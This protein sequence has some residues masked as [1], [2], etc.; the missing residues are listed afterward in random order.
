MLTVAREPSPAPPLDK[1]SARVAGYRALVE[2]DGELRMDLGP[3]AV[4][5]IR[6][7]SG[8]PSALDLRLSTS[9]GQPVP[10]SAPERREDDVIVRVTDEVEGASGRL[11]LSDGE[12]QQLGGWELAPAVE[13]PES[14]R[15]RLAAGEDL[16]A[17]G[18]SPRQRVLARVEL[19]RA[20]QREGDADATIAAWD[21]VA[22]EAREAG[23]PTEV[24]RG[25]RAAAYHCLRARRFDDALAHLDEAAGI[26]RR[27]RNV[28]GTLR[29]TDY[30]A[31]VLL[32]RS[33]YREAEAELGV[34]VARA[35]R[36]GLE[37]EHAWLSR[38][39]AVLLQHL[40]R[41]ADALTTLAGLRG[42]YAQASEHERETF[43]ERVSYDIDRG[44]VALIG[45]ERGAVPLNLEQPAT[46]FAEARA[47]AARVGR[48]DLEADA[49]TNLL[50]IAYLRNDDAG[51]ATLV[52]EL[53]ALD[54]EHSGYSARFVEIVEAELQLRA[55]ELATARAG[56]AAARER[57]LAESAGR[58]SEYSWRALYGIARAL[59]AQG[60]ERGGLA[61]LEEAAAALCAVV[62]QTRIEGA[63]ALFVRDRHELF[64][65]GVAWALEAGQPERAFTFAQRSQAQLAVALENRT[66]A[67]R[68]S[69]EERAQYEV[70]RGQ[71]LDAREAHV[72]AGR[73]HELLAESGRLAAER[74][75]DAER[76]AL[77]ARFERAHAYLDRV[78]PVSAAGVSL[79]EVR[80]ALEDDEALL[81]SADLGDGRVDFLVRGGSQVAR[82]V[83]VQQRAPLEPLLESLHDIALLYVVASSA[84]ARSLHRATD[85]AGRLWLERFSIAYLPHAGLLGRTPVDASQPP[86][87]VSDPE[88]DLPHA[89]SEA[90]AVRRQ[91]PSARLLRGRDATRA[92]VLEALDGASLFH[93][94]GH[95]VLDAAN[96]WD[97]R[98][99]LAGG[100]SLTVEDLLVA[101]PRAGVVVL[102]GCETGEIGA[103]ESIG[104]ADGLVIA[105]ADAVVA[106]DGALDDVAAS[107]FVEALYAEGVA[108]EPAAAYRRAALAAHR[109][110]D[111]TWRGFRVLGR[112]RAGGAR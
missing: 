82:P 72:R 20:A 100:Q 10:L 34:A 2:V 83:R 33:S 96:P 79:A 27:F 84:R 81:F 67:E 40:G 30:R 51:A 89:R 39:Q 88:G 65:D 61:R 110:G 77:R 16:D 104:L 28:L 29:G 93:F 50:W 8:E 111:D 103:V 69:D 22:V 59:R 47:M 19:A 97:A 95:G 54:H 90:E 35:R 102:S 38:S 86:L 63:R 18:L 78:A 107:R 99:A 73:A 109:A 75:R 49:V 6:G 17:L 15:E 26:D 5:R 94:A 87:L 4:F 44:W 53:S 32:E 25:L 1:V 76:D 9:H 12:G 48:S 71:Y 37:N 36:W 58:E 31:L 70:L 112:R 80:A 74:A 13:L 106:H 21:R 68:L 108:D 11:V 3:S 64:R 60:R 45:M 23:V 91:L 62:A 42:Y 57:A 43:L 66:R 105:G 14:A 101:R 92:A 52:A 85:T 41:H 98:L 56:F 7:V 46:V 24:S 55:G